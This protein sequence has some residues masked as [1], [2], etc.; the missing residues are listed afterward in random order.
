[1]KKLFFS[2]MM[3][4]ASVS[5]HAQNII[6]KVTDQSNGQPIPFASVTIIDA[7]I[8][9]VT[10]ENGEF[11]LSGFTYPIKLRVSH[12]SYLQSE[13][14]LSQRGEKLSIQ[15]VPATLS[16]NTVTIDP[17]LGQRIV[18]GALEKA[19]ANSDRNYYTNAF[20][21]QLS[22]L[23]D[24]PNQI[25]EL[26]YDLKW[27]P[28]RVQGWSAKHSRFAEMND[29]L[30]FSMNNQSYL[31]FSYS[32]YLLQEKGCKYITLDNLADFTIN[33]ERY[34]EQADQRVAVVSCK[35]NKAKKNQYYV[36]STYYIGM[37]DSNIYRL[38]NNVYN[39]PVALSDAK[40]T[41]PPACNTV[42]TFKNY[43]DGVTVLE[44]VSTKFL[45]NGTAKGS[46]QELRLSVSS[47]LTVFSVDNKISDKNFVTLS[48]KTKDKAVIQSIA[49]DAKFWADNPIVKQT[50]LED[51]F[52][53]MMEN[54]KA[55]GTMTNP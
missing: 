29:G 37:D 54:K 53:K 28:K 44:S 18:K 17:Y 8:A 11:I 15:L 2:L 10:N 16:L 55:F 52:I 22:T 49:Y 12:I 51:S 47:L 6:G 13:I 32:G 42:A 24:K 34:I 3:L 21:R 30:S 31:T 20:Y 45:L 1:M 38:E 40:A 26:F 7:N 19:T 36:N 48:K 23:N 27:N 14:N 33:I 39:V 5:L 4:L 50:S 35:Y 41:Y 9:T 46:G 25:F 43:G